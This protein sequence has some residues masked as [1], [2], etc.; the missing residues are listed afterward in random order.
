[1]YKRVHTY[2]H[3]YLKLD[4]E[5]LDIILYDEICT[6]PPQRLTRT[7]SL[8]ILPLS[9]LSMITV[10]KYLETPQMRKLSIQSKN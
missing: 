8:V 10:F 4:E 3:K 7:N 9:I 2:V 1:M 6:T 5:D